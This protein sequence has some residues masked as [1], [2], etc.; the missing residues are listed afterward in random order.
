MIIA[1]DHVITSMISVADADRNGFVDFEEFE[2]VLGYGS[3]IKKSRRHKLRF[4]LSWIPLSSVT[5]IIDGLKKLYIEKLKPLEVTYQ[6]N[7]FAS[8]LLFYMDARETDN[9]GLDDTNANLEVEEDNSVDGNDITI[10]FEGKNVS[11]I[12]SYEVCDGPDGILATV[13]DQWFSEAIFAKK[14]RWKDA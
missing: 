2:C 5:S 11:S 1:D 4:S 9:M 6:F 12:T 13:T 7:D 10:E 3:S 8:P 14:D